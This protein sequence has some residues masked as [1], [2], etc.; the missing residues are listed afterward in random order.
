[1][2]AALLATYAALAAAMIAVDLWARR[3]G[4]HPVTAGGVLE[5]IMRTH[6][7]RWFV[8]LGWWWLGW[9]LFVR[10]TP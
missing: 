2:G 1:M 7:G 10:S 5:T 8:L 4:H 9:H 3:H 6:A